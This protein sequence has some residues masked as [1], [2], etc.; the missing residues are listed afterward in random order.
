MSVHGHAVERSDALIRGQQED[1]EGRVPSIQ[2][3]SLHT[4]GKGQRP[5]QRWLLRARAEG[6]G[7][8]H[9]QTSPGWSRLQ[10][11]ANVFH[12][13]VGSI[14]LSFQ[15]DLLGCLRPRS[16]R[17]GVLAAASRG[18]HQACSRSP[19]C[20]RWPHSLPASPP[21]QSPVTKAGQALTPA[22]GQ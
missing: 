15:K 5:Q 7:A 12:L 3:S 14:S 4:S 2:R 8:G 6:T 10:G 18:M 21:H 17:L 20:Q 11:C 13:F 22:D 16:P 1:T 9:G 19:F